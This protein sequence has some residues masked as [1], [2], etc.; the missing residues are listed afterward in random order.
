[1][2]IEGGRGQG[3]DFLFFSCDDC[4]GGADLSR[5]E[6]TAP[7]A[8]DESTCHSVEASAEDEPQ[9]LCNAGL[10]GEDEVAGEHQVSCRWPRPL[11][12]GTSCS[13]REGRGEPEVYLES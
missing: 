4:C 8:G 12:G 1:M 2:S 11:G 5:G 7:P 10:L 9:L 3:G 13:S 6:S